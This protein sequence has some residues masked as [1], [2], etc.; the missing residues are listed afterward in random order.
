MRVFF[1]EFLQFQNSFVEIVL[2]DL[3]QPSDW[4]TV[5]QESMVYAQQFRGHASWECKARYDLLLVSHSRRY[6]SV[7]Q[8]L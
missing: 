3:V 2:D 4:K 1:L 6:G 7:S 5:V 8:L